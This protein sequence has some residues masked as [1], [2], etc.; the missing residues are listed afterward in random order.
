MSTISNEYNVRDKIN[1]YWKKAYWVKNVGNTDKR[2]RVIP[3]DAPSTP[4]S[5]SPQLSLGNNK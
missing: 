1:E 5:A 3:V 4:Y 2:I